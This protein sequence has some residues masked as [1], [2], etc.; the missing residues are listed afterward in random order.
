MVRSLFDKFNLRLIKDH[1]HHNMLTAKLSV[2][3][4]KSL[5]KIAKI[6]MLENV[7]HLNFECELSMQLWRKF[8]L[9]LKIDVTRKLFV[10]GFIFIS[11]SFI[12]YSVYN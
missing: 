10:V 9:I 12:F 5:R 7:T 2:N 11:K 8:S 6:A 3:K 1:I 4:I